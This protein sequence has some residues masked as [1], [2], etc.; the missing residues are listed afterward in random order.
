[1]ENECLVITQQS[2]KIFSS[3]KRKKKKVKKCCLSIDSIKP[4]L[5]TETCWMECGRP[6]KGWSVFLL[7]DRRDRGAEDGLRGVGAVGRDARHHRRRRRRRGSAGRVAVGRVRR[8]RRAAHLVVDD[9]HWSER[10]LHLVD[11]G[12]N[13]VGAR[14]VLAQYPNSR[15]VHLHVHATTTT[16][17]TSLATVLVAGRWSG[18]T[19]TDLVGADVG[20]AVEQLLD[21]ERPEVGPLLDGLAHQKQHVGGGQLVGVGQEVGEDGDD[22]FGHGRELDAAGVEGAHQQLAVLAGVVVLDGVVRFGHLLLENHDDVVDVA[23][24]DEVERQRQRLLAHLGV[25]RAQH[26]QHVHHQ[27]LHDTLLVRLLLQSDQPVQHDQLHVVIAL[28]HDDLDVARRRRCN[29]QPSI[30]T[31]PLFTHP[32]FTL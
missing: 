32:L 16:T 28:L 17:T 9:R 4:E 26:A 18:G 8:R 20:E 14:R 5:S 13:V 11:H 21:D 3:S 22:R 12:A 31:F 1:M 10:L 15:P 6:A 23:A 27:F 7:G 25:G 29:R 30:N 19:E 2:M 24:R